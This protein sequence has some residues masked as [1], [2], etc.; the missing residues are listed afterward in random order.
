MQVDPMNSMSKPPETIKRLKLKTGRLLSSFAFKFNLRLYN[1]TWE[2]L[3]VSPFYT[4][5]TAGGFRSSTFRLDAS[6]LR[7]TF[8][9][10]SDRKGSG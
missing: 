3:V 5:C 4:Q 1:E 6:N 2:R 9:N 8:G 7:D 10:F